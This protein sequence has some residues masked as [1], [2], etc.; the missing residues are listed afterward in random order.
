[1]VAVRQDRLLTATA[2]NRAS[3]SKIIL[4]G[5][6]FSLLKQIE[7]FAYKIIFKTILL[8]GRNKKTMDKYINQS[9]S[10]RFVVL[11]A[12]TI[13][14]ISAIKVA[15]SFLVPIL[16]SVLFAVVFWPPLIKMNNRGMSIGMALGVV[17]I[18]VALLILLLIGFL[19]ITIAS[20]GEALPQYQTR[21]AEQLQAL[22]ETVRGW[23]LEPATNQRLCDSLLRHLYAGRSG[24]L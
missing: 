3:T 1:M 7:K 21:L 16:L 14:I 15:A 10:V 4:S 8:G 11:A 18:G 22:G 13:I 24:W 5:R 12:G 6:L 17:L 9:P 2:K 20:F 23:G 19:G